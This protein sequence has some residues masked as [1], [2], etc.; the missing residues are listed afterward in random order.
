MGTQLTETVETKCPL[1]ADSKMLDFY[2][3][4]CCWETVGE[5]YADINYV[6][7]KV[8]LSVVSYMSCMSEL[9]EYSK[10]IFLSD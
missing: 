5:C 7:K 8:Y 4:K 3:W 10:K 2:W 9:Y 6:S 1:Y